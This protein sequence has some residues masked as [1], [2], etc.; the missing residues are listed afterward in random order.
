MNVK[1]KINT[2][3]TNLA[4]LIEAKLIGHKLPRC[5]GNMIPPTL[6][7]VIDIDDDV[8]FGIKESLDPEEIIESE[9]KDHLDLQDTSKE[10]H[11]YLEGK[12]LTKAGVESIEKYKDGLAED[13][14][15]K[16]VG[17]SNCSF[18]DSCSKLTEHF[19]N[20]IQIQEN[21]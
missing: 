9:V 16:I 15:S 21:S 12:C 13:Y 6:Y 17:C 11:E 8:I 20:I 14:T 5:F 7:Q 10:V 2:V 19:L 1:F 3:G 18:I 4:E